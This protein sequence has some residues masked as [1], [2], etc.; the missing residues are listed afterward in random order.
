M[1]I[2]ITTLLIFIGVG[3]VAQI[4]D[5]S[6]GMAY[7]VSSNTF[8]L[9]FGVPPAIA[10]ACVHVAEMFT[11]FVSGATHWRLGN[12][13]WSIVKR[14]LI[15]GI[16]GGV[17]GAYI[18][19]TI[20]GNVIKPY[21]SGYLLIMGI[22]IIVKAFGEFKE[23]H[24]KWGLIPLGAVGGFFD[25]IGG[26]GWGPLVT[27]TM[28]ANGHHPR[29]SIGSVNFSEFFVTVAESITFFLTL[30]LIKDWVYVIG[31][32]IGGMVAAPIAATMTKRLPTKWLMLGVGVIIIALSIRTLLLAV[33]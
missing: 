14:L 16:I 20:D 30:G 22:I 15:P 10:S 2:D 32:I 33:L 5:G 26:G 24:L 6:L 25:A 12:V 31:L 7:G 27:T 9:S 17:L 19:T 29:T 1:Q 21:I 23:R 28:V 11:T 18:L 4:I 8:L 13:D 3:F